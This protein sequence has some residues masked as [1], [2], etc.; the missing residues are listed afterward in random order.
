MVCHGC[1]KK[2][3]MDTAISTN[4][5]VEC[6]DKP[7]I[8]VHNT[9]KPCGLCVGGEGER[10]ANMGAVWG[11]MA[12]QIF[13]EKDSKFRERLVAQINLRVSPED[14]A[15]KGMADVWKAMMEQSEKSDEA[16]DDGGVTARERRLRAEWDNALD[17]VR[18]AEK[19]T[20]EVRGVA[21]ERQEEIDRLGVELGEA[22]D[23]VRERG[24]LLKRVQAAARAPGGY[25]D[26]VDATE[27]MAAE[28]WATR[29]SVREAAEM[30]RL[31][32]LYQKAEESAWLP[33]TVQLSAILASPDSESLGDAAKRVVAER[34]KAVAGQEETQKLLDIYRNSEAVVWIPQAEE[35]RD[36]L[37]AGAR[38]GAP[39]AAK[40]VMAERDSAQMAHGK[41]LEA[42]SDIEHIDAIGCLSGDCD[43]DLANE[44]L[45]AV[46]EDLRAVGKL[47]RGVLKARGGG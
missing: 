1:Q 33:M 31:P 26:A 13:V 36:I 22:R 29:E 12:E 10:V 15:S 32:E 47:V 21:F 5:A 37:K 23:T 40:R 18:Q 46:S 24:V 35:L 11:W 16:R 43:H 42:L 9:D 44:C 7:D 3:P 38:E 28:V 17:R 19:M 14:F 6:C 30:K 27:T 20:V 8:H 39:V 45:E 41:T 4:N 25:R 2:Y 34:D